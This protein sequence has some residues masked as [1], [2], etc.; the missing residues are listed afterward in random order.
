[1]P[2][3]QLKVG[4]HRLWQSLMYIVSQYS[5][6]CGSRQPSQLAT[7][8]PLSSSSQPDEHEQTRPLVV[9]QYA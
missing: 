9:E 7:G 4:E 6:E 1:M 2:L 3:L 5:D 8:L